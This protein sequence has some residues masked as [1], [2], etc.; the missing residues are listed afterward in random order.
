VKDR[1]QLISLAALAIGI[2]LLVA[3]VAWLDMRTVAAAA[4]HLGVALPLVLAVSGVWHLLRT[5]AWSLSF[6]GAAPPFG[7]LWRVRLAAE[8]FSFVTIRGVAGEPLK[9]LLLADDASPHEATAAV[10]LERIAYFVV[11][12]AIVAMGAAVALATVPMPPAWGRIFIG[13]LLGA[14]L[15]LLAGLVALRGNGTYVRSLVERRDR[16]RGTAWRGRG[17]LRFIGAVEGTLLALVRGDRRRLI[18]LAL[19]EAACFALMA[20]EVWVVLVPIGVPASFGQALAVETFSRVASMVSAFIPGNI[21]ALEASNVIVLNAVGAAS[22]A[23]AV[24]L[25]R[26]VRGLWWAALGFASYPRRRPRFPTAA[27]ALVIP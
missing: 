23:A 2:A 13:L 10:A 11:T 14:V 22:G 6:R 17:T 15:P 12:I 25:A 4:L 21:G 5:M 7:R 16:V 27:A 3:T 20:A 18:R 26:R 9:V 19:L 1:R 8:A 24:A